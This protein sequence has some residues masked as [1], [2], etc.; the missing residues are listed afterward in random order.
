MRTFWFHL[1]MTWLKEFMNDKIKCGCFA[2]CIDIC[3]DDM[4]LPDCVHCL[5]PNK[6]WFISLRTRCY[7]WNNVSK[8]V[9]IPQNLFRLVFYSTYK[10]YFLHLL[11]SKMTGCSMIVFV[12]NIILQQVY[13]EYSIQNFLVLLAPSLCCCSR[14][15]SF[16]LKWES[17]AC[18]MTSSTLHCFNIKL[19]TLRLLVII[20]FEKGIFVSIAEYLFILWLTNWHIIFGVKFI[21]IRCHIICTK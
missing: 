16:R 2:Y 12:C 15:F 17:Y 7:N 20:W 21:R 9:P 10:M 3:R 18:F 14:E 4:L 8:H 5:C 13:K 6:I 19:C 11:K 1:R